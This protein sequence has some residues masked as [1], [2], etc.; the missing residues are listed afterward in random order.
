MTADAVMPYGT[1]TCCPPGNRYGIRIKPTLYYHITTFMP[2]I[3]GIIL[4]DFP[5]QIFVR[6]N[7]CVGKMENSMVQLHQDLIHISNNQKKAF[8]EHNK[9][10]YISST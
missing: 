4:F 10:F 5:V 7:F 9:G 2:G 3:E 1:G 8:R 6:E